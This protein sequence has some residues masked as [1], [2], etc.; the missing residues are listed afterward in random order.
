M[1]L[2][3]NP[4]GPSHFGDPY[5]FSRRTGPSRF[6]LRKGIRNEI[7]LACILS[8]STRWNVGGECEGW[9]FEDTARPELR[10]STR[11][12]SVNSPGCGADRSGI[13]LRSDALREIMREAI[14]HGKSLRGD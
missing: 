14:N 4:W 12:S 11:S 10:R 8:S 1:S 5:I 7:G 13:A 3:V 9:P 2:H 6:T